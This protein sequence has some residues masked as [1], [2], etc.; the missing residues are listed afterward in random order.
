M[1]CKFYPTLQNIDIFQHQ[2]SISDLQSG[3]NI[4][5]NNDINENIGAKFT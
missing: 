4:I 3:S 1:F 2:K 5:K